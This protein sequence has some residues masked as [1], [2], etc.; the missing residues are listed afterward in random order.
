MK[1]IYLFMLAVM[2]M[3]LQSCLIE[4]KQLFC[5]SPAERVEAYLNEYRGLLTSAEN[6]WLMEYYPGDA[7]VGGFA[8]I[9]KFTEK[10]VTAWFELADD[11]SESIT[12]LYKLTQ[13]DGPALV[14]D[15][16]NEYLHFFANPSPDMYQG[17]QGDHDFKIMGSNADKTEVYLRGKRSGVDLTLKKFTGNPGEYLQTINTLS[18]NWFA[19]AYGI[20]VSGTGTGSGSFINNIFNF[21]FTSGEGDT[22]VTESLSIPV[23]FTDKGVSFYEPV[24]LGGVAYEGLTFSNEAL[25]SEDGKVMISLIFPPLNQLF[26]EGNWFIAYSQLGPEGKYYFD[27]IKQ[28]EDLLGEELQYA[29]LGSMLYPTNGFGFQF[30]SSGYG[31]SLDFNYQLEGDDIVTLQYAGKYGAANG[32][33]YHDNAMFYYALM[34]FGYDEPRTFKLTADDNR[35][36]TV[37]TMTEVGNEAHTM[38]LFAKQIAYPLEN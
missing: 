36:P 27:V 29:F 38:T 34:P 25:V 26:V 33:W 9:V 8:Y 3:M 23:C 15:T 2:A 30:I 4:D 18:S 5:E 14:F 24:E 10:D 13:D 20:T 21:N 28:I 6:G 17:Y 11:T 22:A 32:Q 16:F 1:K 19:P 31:G 7:S 37:I 35:N 12:S